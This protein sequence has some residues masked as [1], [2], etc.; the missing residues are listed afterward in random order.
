MSGQGIQ[1]ET[2]LHA[3]N[4]INGLILVLYNYKKNIARN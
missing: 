4:R 1:A 3:K 2:R